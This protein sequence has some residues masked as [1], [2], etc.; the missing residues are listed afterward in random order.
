VPEDFNTFFEDA[1]LGPD[2]ADGDAAN[3]DAFNDNASDGTAFDDN[4]L[5]DNAFN[6]TAQSTQQA[7]TAAPQPPLPPK[8]RKEMRRQREHPRNTRLRAIIIVFVV[9]GIVAGGGYFS[10][11]KIRSWAAARNS[12]GTQIADYPGPGSGSVRI[13]VANGDDSTQVAKKLKDADVIKSEAA[14]T[15]AVTANSST[16]YPG[17]Y[18]LKLHMAAIDVVKILSDQSKATG[19]LEVRSGERASDI[20]ANAASL[21]GISKSDFQSIVDK[22]GVGILPPEAGGKFEGWLEPGSYDVK[23]IGSA[24]G[25]MKAM[26]SKRVAQ[27]DA[28]GA[29]TGAQRE[30]LLTIASIAESEVNSQE[31]Y[32]KVVRVIL[33]RLAKNMNLGMDTT[34]AYG[35]GISA[36]KLT[37]DMLA[38]GS[39]PYN[40][41][42][43]AGLPPTPISN[44][45]DDVLK[46]AMNPPAGDWLY[47]VTTNLNTGETKFATTEDEF[48][49]IRDEY[50]QTNSNAN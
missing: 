40:T 29:P 16:L 48:W 5:D 1:G 8:S 34:V 47:F 30:K 38:N 50:K 18:T 35:L 28:M 12:S 13:S 14:F 7:G 43:N 33:N 41:R 6:G 3:S 9:L 49:K 19:F 45:S 11:T 37:D 44:P 22:G 31:Y 27:L 17:I 25:I 2:A 32:G 10:Y 23:S 36:D 39:N 26:V 21:S 24:E 20:I 42:V 15:A 46:D 4:M